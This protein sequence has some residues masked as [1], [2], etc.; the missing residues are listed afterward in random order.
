M[1]ERYGDAAEL[2]LIDLVR[3]NH[4]G[5]L[6][7]GDA[8]AWTAQ[9]AG[10]G[11]QMPPNAPENVGKERIRQWFVGL[12]S[13]FKVQFELDVE[14]V[15]I[16]GDWAFERGGYAISLNPVAGGPAMVDNGKYITIY[17]QGDGNGWKIAR[18]IW[19]SNSPIPAQ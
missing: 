6:N 16:V 10:D 19:N 12:L 3:D 2:R 7:T 8:E 11:V 1:T 14:E 13:A 9:F 15:R 5:A 4:V 18:D 17:R